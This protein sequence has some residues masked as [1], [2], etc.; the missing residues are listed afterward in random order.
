[1]VPSTRPSPL[2]PTTG[3]R[4][5]AAYTVCRIIAIEST[6]KALWCTIKW[7]WRRFPILR[8]TVVLDLVRCTHLQ[9]TE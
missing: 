9:N 7:L 4:W 2:M 8:I 1:M 5:S 6:K 3:P